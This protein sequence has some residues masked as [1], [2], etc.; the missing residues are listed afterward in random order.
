MRSMRILFN[1]YPTH[2][3]GGGGVVKM[4]KLREYLEKLGHRVDY[5]DPWRS[6]VEDYDI[7]HH[8]SALKWDYPIIQFVKAAGLKIVIETMYWASYRHA[9]HAPAGAIGRIKMLARH[10][11]RLGFPWILPE[12][13]V[14]GLA[15]CLMPNSETEAR[16]LARHYRIPKEQIFVAFNGVEQRFAEATPNLF[17][18]QY[19]LKDFVL[20]T[21]MFEAR[22]NQLTL[23]RA[24]KGTGIPLVLIGNCP[25]VHRWYYERCRQEADD[26]VHFVDY[27]D[28]DDP[29]LA[30]AY[31]AARVLAMPSW[32]ET[33]GKSALE[34]ALTATSIVMTTYA[35]GA[36][37][38]FGDLAFYVDPG[39]IEEIRRAVLHA[40]EAPPNEALKRRVEEHFL[41][42]KVVAAREQGYERLT[43]R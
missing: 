28:H 32:H 27:L 25:A 1:A 26:Q 30:S 37:E 14:L 38:Y 10:T 16:L 23:I 9:L 29:L 8:F 36:R 12:R 2:C 33:T 4:R 13:R 35:P 41:W 5:F 21:G 22:K 6:R 3:Q 39:D 31:A 15:D 7:Y 43:S 34:A 24:M 17:V 11:L 19:G 20:A 40:Y 18:T 42:A